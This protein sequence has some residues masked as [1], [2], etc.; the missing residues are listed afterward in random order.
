MKKPT[1]RIKKFVKDY[2]TGRYTAGDCVKNA[3]YNFKN[4][5]NASKYSG[6]LLKKPIVLNEIQRVLNQS[7]LTVENM[8]DKLALTV[9]E[10]INENSK[11]TVENG[12]KALELSLRLYGLLDN[13]TT[14]VENKT[15]NISLNN[16]SNEELKA[17]LIELDQQASKYLTPTASNSDTEPQN[18]AI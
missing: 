8:S 6:Q 3:G 13:N 4:N 10:G 7:G 11:Y 9:N 17:K 2:L 18:T 5:Q 1:P 12:L 14:K 16:L 15:L